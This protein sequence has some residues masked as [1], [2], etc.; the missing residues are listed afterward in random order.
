MD[1]A[2]GEQ[3]IPG[4]D[5]QDGTANVLNLFID[6]SG[7][8]RTFSNVSIP[9]ITEATFFNDIVLSYLTDD[10]S[11][12][13][14]IPTPFDTLEF[15]FSVH[16]TYY[17]GMISLDYGDASGNNFS[18]SSGDLQELR[19][20]IIEASSAGRSAQGPTK[21]EI[22]QELSRADVDINNYEEVTS[23]YNLH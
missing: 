17:L 22:L 20:V 5:G 4:Q 23:Y 19:V 11:N 3:G 21:E 10:G 12:W 9:E 15:D 8:N 7:F 6:A 13:V 16:V 2:Q 1:G 18:I 14:P